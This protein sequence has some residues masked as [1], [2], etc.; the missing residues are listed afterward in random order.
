M[1]INSNVNEL[2]SYDVK[3]FHYSET[4]ELIGLIPY[5]DYVG[6]TDSVLYRSKSITIFYAS[7]SLTLYRSGVKRINQFQ[8]NNKTPVLMIRNN[9]LDFYNS[10]PSK[11][12]A[13]LYIG[14][15]DI[16]DVTS[17]TSINKWM[18]VF[19]D[20][21]NILRVCMDVVLNEDHEYNIAFVVT[22]VFKGI[23]ERIF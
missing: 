10:Y 22:Y 14:F 5:T 2:K 13:I 15:V 20:S 8:I 21:N 17:N 11:D 18:C 7:G 16:Y 12:N 3:R 9:P 19:K 1:C 6:G 23:G 4:I